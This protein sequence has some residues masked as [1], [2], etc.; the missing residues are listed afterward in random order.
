MRYT[1]ARFLSP[2]VDIVEH[3]TV[4]AIGVQFLAEHWTNAIVIGAI[5]AYIIVHAIIRG[6]QHERMQ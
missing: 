4:I 5:A 6:V 1:F 3:S 2:A